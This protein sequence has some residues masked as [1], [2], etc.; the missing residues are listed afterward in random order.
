MLLNDL[1]NKMIEAMKAR[2]KER[3]TV[4]RNLL[5]E[6]KNAKIDNP[7]MSEQDEIAVVRKE[8][9]KRKDAIEAL[10]RA[11]GKQTS[12]TESELLEKKDREDLE[13]K[14]LEE[15]LPAEM[16]DEELDSMV[17]EAIIYA[18][19]SGMADMGRVMGEVM[20]RAG[21]KA[22]G[23][24]VSVVVKDKLTDGNM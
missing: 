1:Q 7:D 6:I 5:S 21:G 3:A 13:L 16:S 2:D 12:S 10:R 18:K 4:L 9:K 20:K 19:A 11:Q 22:S 8:V 14:I 17:H 15:F 24:R 23:D